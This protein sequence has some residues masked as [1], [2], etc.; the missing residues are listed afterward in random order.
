M[1][2]LVVRC[3]SPTDTARLASC[4]AGVVRPGDCVVLTGDLGAGKT[5]FVKAAVAAMRIPDA[6][7][8]PTFTLVHH[9]GTGANTVVHADLYRLERTGELADLG[10]DEARDDGAVAFVEW[11]DRV[12]DELGKVLV[13][14]FVLD[15][16]ESDTARRVTVSYRGERW[17]R[18]WT[19]IS[20]A[21][22]GEFADAVA[23]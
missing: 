7:T 13:L 10:L 12:G 14:T 17:Q 22:L 8:S 9:Y 3:E 6:V 21:L 5:T 16:S 2:R 4:V 15:D 1:S 20:S 11:G 19:G 23:Q 18:R